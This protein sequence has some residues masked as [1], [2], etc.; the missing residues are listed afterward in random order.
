MQRRKEKK[1]IN[2]IPLYSIGYSS[3]LLDSWL[4]IKCNWKF[5]FIISTLLIFNLNYTAN[6]Q[7]T[8]VSHNFDPNFK[9]K[10]FYHIKK[11][12]GFGHRYAQTTSETRT[13]N[14]IKNHFAKTGLP[15]IK[16]KFKFESFVLTGYKIM[17]NNR[18]LA[19]DLIIFNPYKQKLCYYHKNS[20]CITKTKNIE[21]KTHPRFI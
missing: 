13:L 1:Y 17:L 11:L 3:P 12:A 7:L 4:L 18:Q 9:D 16:E 19:P 5:K 8:S 10:V 6:A 20:R 14:Y 21:S 2:I 15:V